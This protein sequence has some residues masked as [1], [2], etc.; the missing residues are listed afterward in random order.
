MIFN[1]SCSFLIPQ[2]C[3][4]CK[5]WDFVLSYFIL[6]IYTSLPGAHGWTRHIETYQGFP[7]EGSILSNWKNHRNLQA[8]CVGRRNREGG[9][10]AR[11]IA[12]VSMWWWFSIFPRTLI[13][14]GHRAGI[15]MILNHGYM[16]DTPG[17]IR[18]A[19]MLHCTMGQSNQ[20]LS[21]SWG[22]ERDIWVAVWVLVLFES[23]PFASNVYPGL[24]IAVVSPR[25]LVWVQIGS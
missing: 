5:G 14:L 16:I 19:R 3:K 4:L 9:S 18:N 7:G 21:L 2:D 24:R 25:K 10:H 17:E 11:R 22:V 12:Y 15:S 20:N 23:S 13:R 6:S 8:F 1:G